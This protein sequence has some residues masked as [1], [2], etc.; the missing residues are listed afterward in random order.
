MCVNTVQDVLGEGV[1]VFAK[2]GS[3]ACG[4]TMAM[5]P[6]VSSQARMQAH[7]CDTQNVMRGEREGGREGVG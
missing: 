4:A 5:W 1:L 3:L 7:I 6:A 2:A